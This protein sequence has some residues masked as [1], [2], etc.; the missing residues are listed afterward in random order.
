MILITILITIIII[1]IIIK[2]RNRNNQNSNIFEKTI[3]LRYFQKIFLKNYKF[4]FQRLLTLL[5]INSSIVI[6]PK[7]Y[8]IIGQNIVLKSKKILK[9]KKETLKYFLTGFVICVCL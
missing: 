7:I 8:S 9:L 5:E 4:S 2:S 1:T 6:T 3:S